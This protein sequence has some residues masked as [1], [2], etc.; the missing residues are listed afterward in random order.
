MRLHGQP[1]TVVRRGAYSG[2]IALLGG[3]SAHYAA[4]DAML[5]HCAG[6]VRSVASEEA[7]ALAVRDP[8]ETGKP[9]DVVSAEIER[10]FYACVT[11]ERRALGH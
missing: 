8:G 6:R 1:I 5:A 10:V 3:S 7:A 2:E 9:R 11:R 4:E